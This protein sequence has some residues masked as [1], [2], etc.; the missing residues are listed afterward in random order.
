MGVEIKEYVK[1]KDIATGVEKVGRA[2]ANNLV[3]IEDTIEGSVA[4]GAL[5]GLAFVR[6]QVTCDLGTLCTR[7]EVDNTFV[8]QPKRIQFDDNGTGPAQFVKDISE[9]TIVSDY[10]GEKLVFCCYECAA[11]YF[12]KA[13][14]NTNVIEFPGGKGKRTFRPTPPIIDGEVVKPTETAELIQP[15]VP[16]AESDEPNSS[17]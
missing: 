3:A 2:L 13:G 16:E 11:C 5:V 6:T 4:F 7:C 15:E 14:K 10:K 9:I 12:R 1:I 8:T 17:D